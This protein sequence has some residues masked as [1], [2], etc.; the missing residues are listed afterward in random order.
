MKS[1]TRLSWAAFAMALAITLTACGGGNTPE[2]TQVDASKT[3]TVLRADKSENLDP[4]A[5][6]SGGDVTVLMQ[7]YETLVRPSVGTANVEWEPGLAKSW[8]INDDKSVYTFVIRDGVTFHDGT[9]LDAAAVKRSLDRLVD[10]NEKSKPVGRPYRKGFFG[11]VT[12]IS[13]DGDK[14]II[15]L[16]GPNPRFLSSIGIHPAMIVSPKA[17]EHMEGIKNPAERSSW[18]TSHPAG[19]GPYTI[20]DESDYKESGANLTLTAFKEYW[21]GGAPKIE[22]VVFQTQEEVRQRTQRL[23]AGD[24]QFADNLDP[25]DWRDL[26]ANDKVT[27]HTW[28]GMNLCYLAMNVPADSGFVT[29]NLD[30]RKAIALAIDREPMVAKFSGKAVPQHVLLPPPAL[31]FPKGYMPPTDKVPRDEAIERA[32]Q[33]IKN[34]GAEGAKLEL[35]MPDVARPYLLYPNEIA[36][37]IQQQ[38]KQV[39]LEVTLV[40]SPM[41]DITGRIKSNKYPLVLLGWMGD[42]GEPDNFWRPLLGGS[43]GEPASLN[44]ARFYNAEV[45]QRIDA[46]GVETDENKRQKMYEDLEKWVFET[47]RPMVPLLSAQRSFAWT[48][49]LKGVQVDS[50]GQFH[51]HRASIQE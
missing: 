51:L 31:G 35:L 4:Q 3:I 14:V 26:E 38:L 48:S 43:D 27:L 23:L 12:S 34:A 6:D 49:K 45:M 2:L 9:K 40:K 10:E 1:L 41:K 11:G 13:T 8:T 19:T 30:V 22:R 28:Q 25:G 46:A 37:L 20:S 33:L 24:I 15:K 17:I 39:G 18:L 32:K 44:A 42:S 5:T 29:S 16:K 21:D 36:N 50:T 47:F 7:M